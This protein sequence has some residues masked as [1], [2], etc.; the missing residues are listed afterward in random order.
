[1]A[2]QSRETS[3]PKSNIASVFVGVFIVSLDCADWRRAA[4]LSGPALL[5]QKMDL[6]KHPIPAW[7]TQAVEKLGDNTKIKSRRAGRKWKQHYQWGIV[8]LSL[9]AAYAVRRP[10]PSLLEETTAGDI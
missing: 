6:D 3:E 1:M 9:P 8:G 7:I 5:A 4:T 2:A 10:A